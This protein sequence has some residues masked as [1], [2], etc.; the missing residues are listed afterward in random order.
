MDQLDFLTS[1]PSIHKQQHSHKDTEYFVFVPLLSQAELDENKE[2]DV[3][4]SSKVTK[5]IYTMSVQKKFS[6]L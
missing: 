4:R 2:K 1:S 5:T 6:H 3:K